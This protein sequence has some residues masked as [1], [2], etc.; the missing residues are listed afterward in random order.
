M[1]ALTGCTPSKKFTKT[2]DEISQRFGGKKYSIEPVEGK[3]EQY[4]IRIFNA[5]VAKRR[6]HRQ[7]AIIE[8]CPYSKFAEVLAEKEDHKNGKSQLVIWCRP[9]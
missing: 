6:L 3:D 7:L 5:D 4:L 9:K 1:I 8:I 2:F